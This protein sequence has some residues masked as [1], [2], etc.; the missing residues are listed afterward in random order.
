MKRKLM[1]GFGGGALLLAGVALLAPEPSGNRGPSQEQ[2]TSRSF[3]VGIPTAQEIRNMLAVYGQRVE[4]TE[5]EIARLKGQLEASEERTTAARERDSSTLESLIDELRAPARIVDAPPAPTG[6]RFRTY[7]FKSRNTRSLHIPA[8]SFGEATLLSG[9]FAPTTGDPLPVLLRLDVALVGPQRSRIPLRGAFLVGKAQGD[10]NARRATVQIET[11]SAVQPDGSS[12][13]VQV[14]AWVVDEDGIQGL[15]G[16]YVWHADEILGLAAVSGALSGGAQALA[17]SE[18]LVQATPLGGLQEAVTGNPLRFS[19]ARAAS[20]AF[21]R[22][23]EAVS[24][25]LDEIVPAIHVANSRRVTVAFISG[26]TLEGWDPPSD[27]G[28]P[29]EGLDQ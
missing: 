24:K 10:A 18:T 11:L 25:R 28:S 26:V 22:L 20:A 5:R 1:I 13:D 3:E 14:N 17:E 4:T 19:G 21:D 2:E 27:A 16:E 6:P 29:F 23:G 15:R 9:V 8:G 12:F 7:E